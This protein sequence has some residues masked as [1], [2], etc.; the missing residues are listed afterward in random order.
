MLLEVLETRDH[1][2]VAEATKSAR[3][4]TIEQYEG[5][6]GL[7]FMLTDGTS[8]H[9]Y[10]D[11]QSN[12]EYYTLFLDQLGE[13]IVA[14]SEPIHGMR[15]DPIPRGVLYTVTSDLDVETSQIS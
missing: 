3:I 10:R 2:A 8:L 6:T 11:Y 13:V 12:G 7:N 14:T 4:R 1:A 9:L 5:F 15:G